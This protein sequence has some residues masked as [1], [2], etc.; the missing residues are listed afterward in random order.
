MKTIGKHTIKEL[1][2]QIDEIGKQF[3]LKPYV[4]KD[5]KLIRKLL[6]QRYYSIPIVGI[7]N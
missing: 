7:Y 2:P 5:F 3:D 6:V 4:V 1:Q